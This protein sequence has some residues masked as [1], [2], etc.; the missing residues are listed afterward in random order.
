[1]ARLRLTQSSVMILRSVLRWPLR[2]LLTSLGLA[3]AVASV[4]AATF[5]DDAL[6]EI[7]DLAFHQTN[8]Q[9]ATLLFDE[10][11][12]EVALE[13]V[14]NLPGVLQAESQQFQA[15]ILRHGH[16]SKRVSIQSRRPGNDLSRVLNTEGLAVDVPPGGIVLSERL[17]DHLD[18]Q[19]GE[20]IEVE[21][22]SGR[23][24]A[25][26]QSISRWIPVRLTLCTPPSKPRRRSRGSSR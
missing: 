8:R 23:L 1:M 6:D 15:A 26:P 16:L 18:V 10:D 2:S 9:D 19:A 13:D 11:I 20:T 21:F 25:F 17:A 7:V 12:S 3:L 24:R 5:I 4:I 22:L 14:R